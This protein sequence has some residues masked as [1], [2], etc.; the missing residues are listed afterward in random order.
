MFIVDA[1]TVSVAVV[2]AFWHGTGR[3]GKITAKI[4]FTK[5]EV[6]V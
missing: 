3:V 2:D 6:V 4:Y 1:A 5:V